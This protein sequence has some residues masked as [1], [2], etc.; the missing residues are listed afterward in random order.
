MRPG[1]RRCCLQF[2]SALPPAIRTCKDTQRVPTGICGPPRSTS[3]RA[4]W[5]EVP[6]RPPGRPFISQPRLLEHQRHIDD[7]RSWPTQR[8]RRHV[9][10]EVIK[11]SQG[12]NGHATARAPAAAAAAGAAAAAHG[13]A[14]V[15]EGPGGSGDRWAA[16]GARRAGG[17]AGG[18][19]AGERTDEP[20]GSRDWHGSATT[21]VF[22]LLHP[23]RAPQVR[24]KAALRGATPGQA[25]L[26]PPGGPAA[27]LLAVS[28]SGPCSPARLPAHP[29]PATAA[30]SPPLQL[31]SGASR[32]LSR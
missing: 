16:A 17:R 20:E 3:R 7:C 32:S 25:P 8:G 1:S 18:R 12:R 29:P 31:W 10:T 24:N 4:H 14:A 9:G 15:G 21:L 26:V 22:D 11:A 23:L 28:N 19:E 2:A 27:A 6:V 13:A 5:S 30:P